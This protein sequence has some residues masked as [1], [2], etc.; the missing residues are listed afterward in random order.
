MAPDALVDASRVAVFALLPLGFFGVG[1]ALRG[2]RR[3]AAPCCRPSRAASP[4]RSGC[5]SCSRRP[6]LALL[7]WPLIDLPSAYLLQAATPAGITG[8][9]VAHAYGLDMRFAAGARSRGA[10]RSWSSS[11]SPPA[12]PA[13]A[14]P[15]PAREPRHGHRRRRRRSARSAPGCSCCSAITHDDGPAEADRLADKV[16]ALRIFPDADGRMNEPLG[17]GARGPVHLAVHALR[18]RAPRQPAVLR[19]RRAAP[20][21]PSRSTSA[22]ASASARAA[23]VF[24]AHMAVELVNDGPV[25][26][27]VEVP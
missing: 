26:L 8:L 15:G 25:T 6:L 1:V 10:P 18:R 14:R 2:G 13:D 21:T 17:D 4:P 23:G 3:G 12:P 24:G 11:R 16:R 22:S 27:L 19:R 7:A 5:G 20:S 9:V